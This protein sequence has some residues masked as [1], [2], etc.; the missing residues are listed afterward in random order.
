MFFLVIALISSTFTFPLQAQEAGDPVQD[1]L[2][3]LGVNTNLG[4]RRDP[5]G[6]DL[7]PDY[8]PLGNTFTPGKLNDGTQVRYAMGLAR[9]PDPRGRPAIH[10]GGGI[11]GFVSDTR[12]YP[13]EDLYVVVLVNTTGNL[14]PAAIATEMVDVLLPRPDVAT[15]T[16]EGDVAELVGAYSGAARGQKLTVRVSASG[17]GLTLAPEGAERPAP[18][19]WVEGWTFMLGGQIVTFERNGSNGPAAIVRLD[20]GGGHYVLRRQP[21]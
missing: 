14:S 3:S 19:A 7:P 13:N 17:N 21:G 18:L 1:S 2:N 20:S 5:S 8:S 12:Y 15:R 9:N 16:F 11:F 6:N 10:H 4:E